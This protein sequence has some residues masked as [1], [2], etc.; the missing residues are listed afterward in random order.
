[1]KTCMNTA[2]DQLDVTVVMPTYNRA[3]LVERALDSIR[4]QT[5]PVRRI[6]IVDDASLD[7]TREVARAW[8]Q[9]HNQRLHVEVLPHNVGPAAARNR[10][11]ELSQTAYVAFLDSDDEYLPSTLQ[12]QCGALDAHPDA[13]LSFGDATVASAE[14]RQSHGLFGPRVQMD[15]DAERTEHGHW[16]LVDPTDKLL[17][18]SII[19]TSAICFR[20]VDAVAVGGMPADFRSGEDWLFLL[21]LSRRGRFVFTTDDLAIHHRHDENLTNSG[22]GEFV[23]REKLRGLLALR[24][25]TVGVHLTPQQMERVH[26]MVEKQRGSWRYQL[27]R[28]GWIRYWRGLRG[29]LGQASGGWRR[30]CFNDLRSVFRSLMMSLRSAKQQLT[31]LGRP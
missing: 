30:H 18:A 26:Q 12:R 10:G 23:A 14:G 31:R 16:Q 5:L 28:L 11:I 9:R 21:R 13:V 20:R 2:E 24:A 6:I 17:H 4:A 7:G 1:M 29:P 3:A 22:A 19:P 8:A 25:G 15:V 27:S